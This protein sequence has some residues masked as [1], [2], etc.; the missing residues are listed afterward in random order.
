METLSGWHHFYLGIALALLG[1]ALLWASRNWLAVVGIA[2]CLLGLI[3]MTDDVFQHAMQR[4]YSPGYASPLKKVH[5][6]CCLVCPPISKITGFAD[7]LFRGKN[8]LR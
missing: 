1:F 7:D 3:I 8:P 2:L 5:R 6:V 4:F